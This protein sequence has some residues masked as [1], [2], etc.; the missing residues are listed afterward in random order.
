MKQRKR[1]KANPLRELR[2]GLTLLWLISFSTFHISDLQAQG[3]QVTVRL[4]ILKFNQCGCGDPVGPPDIYYE[5]TIDGAQ[6]SS[7]DNQYD[8][9]L[10]PVDIHDNPLE[11]SEDVDLSKGTIPIIIEMKDADPDADDICDISP[12]GSDLNLSLDLATCQISGDISGSCETEI[13]TEGCFWF[14]IEVTDPPHA[15]GLNVRCLHNPIWPQPGEAVIITAEALDDNAN[16]ITLG[17]VD[18]IEIWIDDKTKPYT[19]SAPSGLNTTSVTYT[20]PSG[21][22]QITYGC[23]VLDDGNKVFTGWRVVQIG[24]PAKGRAVPIL[25]TGPRA[26]R[27][28]IVFIADEDTYAGADDPMFLGQV[29]DL[30]RD[31]YYAE[32]AN[33][34]LGGRL[35]LINQD[36]LNFWL[37]LDTGDTDSHADVRPPSN[38]HTAYNFAETGVLLYSNIGQQDFA[39]RGARVF[40]TE[41]NAAFPARIM[42]HETGHV[43]FGLS[44]EYCKKDLSDAY[45]VSLPYPNVYSSQTDCFTDALALGVA[46]A[47]QQIKENTSQNPNCSVNYYRV[48]SASSYVDDLMTEYGYLTPNPADKRRIDW[49]FDKCSSAICD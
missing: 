10:W 35:F 2:V 27:V 33:S 16:L 44:D 15:A 48:E 8:G 4:Q 45:R 14:K 43:P 19:S 41:I 39:S 12:I 21:S 47:C 18:N 3:Q 40:T 25:Y 22:E 5:V 42:L 49:L 36:T 37:A 34:R 1:F 29:H 38:W 11:F 26:S 20:P 13:L 7:Y 6:K 24:Q 28:D 31:G 17:K 23:R 9:T 46:D 32:N 30:M